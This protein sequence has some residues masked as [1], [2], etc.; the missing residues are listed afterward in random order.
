VG[1][2]VNIILDR[3]DVDGFEA[4]FWSSDPVV[5]LGQPTPSADLVIANSL[6]PEAE[7]QLRPWSSMFLARAADL[8]LIRVELI[9]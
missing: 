7:N 2:Q 8:N 9:E 5:A 4:F 1:R 3:R 6:R